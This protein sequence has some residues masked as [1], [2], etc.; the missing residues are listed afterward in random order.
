MDCQ[1]GPLQQINQITHWLDSSNIYGS[2]KEVAE[3]LRLFE[4]GLLRYEVGADGQEQLPVDTRQG[5]ACTG[6]TQTCAL[7]G[8]IFFQ[9]NLFMRN[10]IAIPVIYS[11]LSQEN[12]I[13]FV[14]PFL[15]NHSHH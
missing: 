3:S 8:R 13:I 1:P 12:I 4:D 11:E 9:K 10:L 7:A 14:N 5:L 15:E 6:T 2:S